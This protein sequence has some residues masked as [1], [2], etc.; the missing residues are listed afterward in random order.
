MRGSHLGASTLV[1]MAYTFFPASTTA[2]PITADTFEDGTTMGWFVPGAHPAP[3]S[4]VATGGPGGAGD[5][6]LQLTALGG[7]G[8]GSRLAALNA[9]QWTGNYQAEG[10]VAITMDVNNFGPDDLVLRLLFEDFDAPGP[11]AN[12]AVTLTGV[13]VPAF[14]GWVS[15]TFSL[16]LSNLAA[17]IGTVPGALE[18]VD[19]LRIFHNPLPD[20]PGPGVGIPPVNVTLGIDNITAITA[21][22]EPAVLLLLTGGM[23]GVV[24]RARK[25]RSAGRS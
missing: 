22:P 15:V 19:T 16:A 7:V 5:N 2:I 1:L 20:F 9:S 17:L 4:N 18:E 14:S 12:L 6:Y 25:R 13:V 21:V 11:P 23:A 3:P 10:V 8:A 24:C